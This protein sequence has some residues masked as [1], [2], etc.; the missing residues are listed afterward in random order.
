MREEE[1]VKAF[2]SARAL[3]HARVCVYSSYESHSV[4]ATMHLRPARQMCTA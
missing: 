3:M 2:V 4:G 1:S